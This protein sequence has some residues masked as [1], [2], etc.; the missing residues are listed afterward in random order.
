VN[1]NEYGVVSNGT[2]IFGHVDKKNVK[3]NINNSKEYK[4]RVLKLINILVEDLIL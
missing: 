1:Y 2:Q 4:L 3:R